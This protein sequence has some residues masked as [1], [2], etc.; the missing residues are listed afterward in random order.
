METSLL[1]SETFVGMA[2]MIIIAF[3]FIIG[4]LHEKGYGCLIIAILGIFAVLLYV[5]S[6]IYSFVTENAETIKTVLLIAIPILAVVGVGAFIGIRK[7]KEKQKIAREIKRQ[8][9]LEEKAR[10]YEYCR[11][12]NEYIDNLLS[13]YAAAPT[14]FEKYVADVLAWIGYKNVKV[15]PPVADCGKDITAVRDDNFYVVEVKLYNQD[16]KISREQIQKLHSAM[17]DSNADRAIFVTTS[18][19]SSPAEEYAAKHGIEIWNGQKL[20]DIVNS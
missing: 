2:F 7:Y 1:E 11:S 10:H 18:N 8:E 6:V 3:I 9:R 17:I 16:H 4:Y 12:C 5:I 15:T 14:D 13:D 20:Y 19:F